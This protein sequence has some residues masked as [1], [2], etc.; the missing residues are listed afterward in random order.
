MKQL[1]LEQN[2]IGYCIICCFDKSL[3]SGVVG[4]VMN[5]VDH[6]HGGGEGR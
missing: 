3:K 1:H 2:H 6:P 5:P 4:V